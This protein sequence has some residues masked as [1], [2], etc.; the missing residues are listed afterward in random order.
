MLA[1]AGVTFTATAQ[2]DSSGGQTAQGS[3]LIEANTGFGGGGGPLAH[4]ANTSFGLTSF[5]GNTSWALG[6]EAGYF[7]ADD[8]AVKLGLGYFDSDGSASGLTYKV[9]G[10]YYINSMIPVQVDLTG[11]SIKD[12]DNNPLWLGLQGG[13]AI[14]LGDMVS[15]EPGLRYNLSLNEDVTDEGLFEFRIGFALHF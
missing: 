7:V 3:W 4:S 2:D 5:D 1:I 12:A 8:L 13:Y 14:F 6:G 10:K 11:S 9:G 15:I